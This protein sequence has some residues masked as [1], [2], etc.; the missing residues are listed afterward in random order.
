VH[1]FTAVVDSVIEEI[2]STHQADDSYYIDEAISNNTKRKSY[3][4]LFE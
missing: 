1:A 2:S 4:S 3:I